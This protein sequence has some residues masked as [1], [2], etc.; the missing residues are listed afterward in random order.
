MTKFRVCIT[1]TV[2]AVERAYVEVEATTAEEAEDIVI[3]AEDPDEFSI[4]LEEVMNWDCE[5]VA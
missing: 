2:R 1:R 3:N 4:V 5:V